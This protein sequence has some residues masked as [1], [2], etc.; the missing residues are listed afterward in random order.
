MRTANP[1]G[2]LSITERCGISFS[3][4]IEVVGRMKGV[5]KWSRYFARDDEDEGLE[6]PACHATDR[7]PS[8]KVVRMEAVAISVPRYCGAHQ[9]SLLR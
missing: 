8:S 7:Y 5:K 2:V 6:S 4:R 9:I 3:D 1:V